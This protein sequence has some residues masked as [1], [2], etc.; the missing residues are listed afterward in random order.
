MRYSDFIIYAD[1]SGDHNIANPAP[2]YPVFVLNCC[3]FRKAS[4][5]MS[6]LPAMTAFKFAHFGHDD[7]VLH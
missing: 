7:V 4:Y 2:N 6:V 5:A 3:V 1:E